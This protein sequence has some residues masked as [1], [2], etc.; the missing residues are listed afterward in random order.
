MTQPNPSSPTLKEVLG[1][2]TDEESHGKT[3]LDR[4]LAEFPQYSTELVDAA[5]E[6]SQPDSEDTTPLA[7]VDLDRIAAGRERFLKASAPKADKLSLVSV[8]V[9]KQ[10]KESL[11]LTRTAVSG[12]LARRVKLE[13]VPRNFLVYFARAIGMDESSFRNCYDDLTQIRPLVLSYRA[14]IKPKPVEQI[15]FA[16]FLRD[17][18]VSAERIEQIYRE[19]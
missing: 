1:Y 17:S 7:K 12:L 4:Y 3:T 18:G 16:Q 6:L 19:G 11:A 5:F 9:Q 10:V 13:S 14:D 8:T 15:D 2:F